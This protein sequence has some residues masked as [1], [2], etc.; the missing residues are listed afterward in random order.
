VGGG[1]GKIAK[2]THHTQPQ[3]GSRR[4]P[5]G[6]SASTPPAPLCPTHPVPSLLPSPP[7]EKQL[8]VPGSPWRARGVKGGGQDASAVA[9][10]TLGRSAGAGGAGGRC[11]WR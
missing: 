4:E 1:L 8:R 3:A 10:T 6:G 2:F 5:E 9:G 7:Q 11:C